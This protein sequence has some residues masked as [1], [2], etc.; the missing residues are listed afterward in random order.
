MVHSDTEELNR[1]REQ[2]E[3]RF[4]GEVTWREGTAEAVP[5]WYEQLLTDLVLATGPEPIKYFSAK[6]VPTQ[7][8]APGSMAVV[9]FTND[10]VTYANLDGLSPDDATSLE[11]VVMA[12]RSLSSFSLETLGEEPIGSTKDI[13]VTVQYPGFSRSLPLAESDWHKRDS[14]ISELITHLR[15]DLVA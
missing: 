13:R 8:D 14:E 15:R 10:L 11:V 4:R 5:G 9:A 7:E 12:R 3:E 1:Q 6:F 2:F